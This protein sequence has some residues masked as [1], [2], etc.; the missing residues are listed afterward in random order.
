MYN[1][2]SRMHLHP[3][4]Q[5]KKW[6]GS[7]EFIK[8]NMATSTLA[9]RQQESSFLQAIKITTMFMVFSVTYLIMRFILRYTNGQFNGQQG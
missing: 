8:T 4:P 2:P 7:G 1:Q 5:N 9:P 6:T 3:H